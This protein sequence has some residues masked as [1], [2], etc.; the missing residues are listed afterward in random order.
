M[1]EFSL[2][3]LIVLI[4]LKTAATAIS[5]GTGFGGGVFSPSLFIG[6]MVGGAYGIVAT[7]A[8]P[9]LSSGHGAYTIIGMGA[10]A[11]AVLG[12]PISTILMVFELTGDYAITI[13]VMISTSVASIITQ[14]VHGY[15]FFTWQLARRG[16]VVSGAHDVGLIRSTTVRDVMALEYETVTPETSI[17]T[18]RNRLLT[19]P[20][21]ELFVVDGDGRLSGVITYADL[22]EAAF[23]T[24]HDAELTAAKVARA[25]PTV[26][27]ADETLESAV[28]MFSTSGEVNLPVVDSKETMRL[29][30]VA[31]EHAV[32]LAFHRALDQARAEQR[33]GL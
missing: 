27:A 11:G 29:V 2:W 32:I 21:G 4:V 6:A 10:V 3:M 1:E 31:Q 26:L 14:Q 25:R 28:K 33:L 13:A 22:H 18:V 15:S 24:S 12:A 23:D 30:G 9:E 8:F 17:A 19:A 5:L 20:F 7:N 16:I